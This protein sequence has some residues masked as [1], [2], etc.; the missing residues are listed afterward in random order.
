MLVKDS[1]DDDDDN[2]G[3]KCT[4]S[5]VADTKVVESVVTTMGWCED[6]LRIGY[7]Q[8]EHDV[9]ENASNCR[10]FRKTLGRLVGR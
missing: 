8:R 3:M 10:R 9:Q 5:V 7:W 1:G 2:E 6:L 4:R